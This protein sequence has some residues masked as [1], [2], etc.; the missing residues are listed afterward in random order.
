MLQTLVEEQLVIMSTEP[1]SRRAPCTHTV[2]RL[3]HAA[4]HY[5]C[6][7]T[8]QAHSGQE[9]RERVG[10]GDGRDLA[11]RWPRGRLYRSWLPMTWYRGC[12]NTASADSTDSSACPAFSCAPPRRQRC[13]RC[14]W[15]PPSA[16]QTPELPWATFWRLH[17]RRWAYLGIAVHGVPEVDGEH[18]AARL[19]ARH[20]APGAL[21]RGT[22]VP[23]A[24]G[25]GPRPPFSLTTLDMP[26][27]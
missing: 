4:F 11:L 13:S 9:V 15:Q 16:S 3:S 18:G 22:V 21:Q 20:A 6:S 19:P 24:G 2:L 10:R 12:S 17:S 25:A 1:N 27:D 5:G 26:G 8:R 7:A 14:A 23:A